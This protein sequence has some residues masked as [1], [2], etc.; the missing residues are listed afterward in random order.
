MTRRV[1]SRR[2]V[3][4]GSVLVLSL[5]FPAHQASARSDLDHR[6][7][8]P[9]PVAT[10]RLAGLL[11]ASLLPS[12]PAPVPQR[13]SRTCPRAAAASA[14]RPR[15]TAPSCALSRGGSLRRG[16][17]RSRGKRPDAPNGSGVHDRVAGRLGCGGPANVPWCT[18]KTGPTVAATARPTA[19][20]GTPDMGVGCL[21]RR[22]R[23]TARAR[24]RG[25]IGSAACR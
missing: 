24:P 13:R 12:Q 25:R 9:R 21:A 3:L 18:P 14:S 1:A 16:L 19:P 4:V 5:T 7:A 11:P 23:P 2:A 10:L 22:G 8:V 17:G 20:A 15:T 6:L